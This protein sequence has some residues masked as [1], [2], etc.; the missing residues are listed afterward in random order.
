MEDFQNEMIFANHALKISESNPWK[1]SRRNLWKCSVNP[2]G[3][4]W[5][6]FQ[7]FPE[8]L[9][10]ILG[11][12]TVIAPETIPEEEFNIMFLDEIPCGI[13]SE[14]FG[15]FPNIIP[16]R[17]PEEIPRKKSERNTWKSLGWSL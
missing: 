10:I 12:I 17:I 11:E 8:F 2:L 14:I 3:T 4:S 7:R 16:W 1:N 9:S 15:K 13:S 6:N 5:E